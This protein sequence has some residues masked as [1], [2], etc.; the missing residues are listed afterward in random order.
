LSLGNGRTN[1]STKEEGDSDHDNGPESPNK[2]SENR[3]KIDYNR[4]IIHFNP[5][6]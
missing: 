1:N 2:E 6:K 3:L 5:K 4:I